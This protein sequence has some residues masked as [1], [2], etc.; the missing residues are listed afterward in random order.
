M[1]G[2]AG[3]HGWVDEGRLDEML[4]CIRHRGPDEGGRHIDEKA[5]VMLGMRRLS[6]VD[7]AGGSQPIYNEDDTV[8]V[9]FNGEIYNRDSL[10]AELESVGH[11]FTT[12]SDTE[13]LV[14]GWEEWGQS[15]PERLNGM[16]AFAVYD[17]T[18]ES[19]FLARD[20]L[21]IKP[22][23]VAT[24]DDGFAFASELR[25]LLRAGVTREVDPRAVHNFFSVRYTPGS[26]TLLSA[27]EKVDPGTSLL[28]TDEGVERRRYWELSPSPVRGSR[29]D[30][31]GQ[32][33]DLLELSV[34]RRLMAD[35]PVGA[36]LSGGLDS[37]AIVGLASERYDGDLQTFSVGFQQA[38]A[39]ESEEA[40]FVADHFGTDHH[41]LTVDIDDMSVFSDLVAHYGE[42]LADAA[43]LPTMLL[44]EYAAENVK[45]VLTGE[46]ADELFA[47]YHRHRL[48][49]KHRQY[50][51][52]VPS[53]AFDAVG[54][55]AEHAG[56]LRRPLRYAASLESD[57]RAILES[58]RRYADERPEMYL[59][60]GHDTASSGLT[61]KVETATARAGNDTLQRLTAYDISYWLPDDLLY[62]VDRASMA[63]SLEA[64]VPFLDHEL[65]EYAYNVPT[66]YKLDGYKRALTDAVDDVVPARILDRDKH[67]F[68]V[69]VSEWFREDHEAIAGWLT[70]THVETAPYIDSDRV[71][72]LRRAHRHGDADHGMTLWKVLTYVAWYHE[73]LVEE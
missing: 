37:S 11:R 1:C 40:R 72:D 34:E 48:L 42:P 20:R 7:L 69:P 49:P 39:D 26:E 25:Q 31:A 19:V 52:H 2:I 41:E 29:G 12:D 55:V 27:V 50:A 5:G 16:F 54:A 32:V 59:S 10:R 9:V 14:H 68:N 24:V 63:A 53:P 65:V 61:G 43:A 36:F 62:K 66:E 13:V 57:E 33:R 70:E 8:A 35:V 60:T 58:A 22:L 23:Y 30:I 71:F 46:G 44:S 6:I 64:R 47:G 51:R 67:G 3:V 73:F 28:V 45:C 56:P 17:E 4:S 21:G 15:L 38:E 18:D